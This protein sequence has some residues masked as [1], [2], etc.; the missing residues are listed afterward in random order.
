MRIKERQVINGW[1]TA[2]LSLNEKEFMEFRDTMQAIGNDAVE[3][4]ECRP[5]FHDVTILDLVSR[6][7]AYIPSRDGC[8]YTVRINDRVDESIEAY[9]AG[10]YLAGFMT[11][12]DAQMLCAWRENAEEER[13]EIDYSYMLL[14]GM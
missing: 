10:A 8:I 14:H 2:T 12:S 4:L 9:T 5:E 1:E 7:G 13:I 6:T 11:E 3:I